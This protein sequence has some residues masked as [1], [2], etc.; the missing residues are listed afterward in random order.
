MALEIFILSRARQTE[1]DKYCVITYLWN[2]ENDT[3]EFIHNTERNSQTQKINYG[4]TLDV[5]IRQENNKDLQYST[6]RYTQ[7]FYNTL[8]QKRV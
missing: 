6:G 2:L 4:Y 3:N 1:K 7:Y 8:S 5:N